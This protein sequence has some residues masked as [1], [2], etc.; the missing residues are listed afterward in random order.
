MISRTEHRRPVVAVIAVM[1]H[2]GSTLLVRR[3]NPPDAGFWGFPGGKI[4]L[5]ESLES[6]VTRELYEETG[7][8]AK[9]GPVLN[10]V[11]VIDRDDR[12][13]LRSHHVLVA[14]ECDWVSGYPVA[15]DD[16]LEARWFPLDELVS[17][18]LKLSRN[19]AKLALQ[20]ASAAR[21][22]G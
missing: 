4:E 5:G 11:D 17:G 12:G 16:A 2:G 18:T 19:V 8:V 7:V 9:P 13:E 20:A 1:I 14:I 22:N 6:A 21:H 3:A 15:G 10:A